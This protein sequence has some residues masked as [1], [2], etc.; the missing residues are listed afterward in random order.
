MAKKNQA[1]ELPP[2]ERI[3]RGWM[4]L[5]LLLGV[6]LTAAAFPTKTLWGWLDAD[7]TT[8]VQSILVS[9]GVALISAG[10]LFIFEPKLRKAVRKTTESAVQ[11]ATETIR[12]D[13]EDFRREIK[14]DV[15]AKIQ[16]FEDRMNSAISDEIS[17]ENSDL[18]H[19]AAEFSYANARRIMELAYE[20][21]AISS[22]QILVD[23]TDDPTSLRIGLSLQFD[24][25]SNGGWGLGAPMTED[26]D[27]YLNA[28]LPSDHSYYSEIWKPSEDFSGPVTHLLKQ[29]EHVGVWGRSKPVDWNG[30]HKRISEALNLAIKSRRQDPEVYP[31]NTPI[32]DVVGTKQMWFISGDS[33]ECPSLGWKINIEDFRA[34]AVA[35]DSDRFFEIPASADRTVIAHLQDRFQ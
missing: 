16:S 10:V 4:L 6:A 23:A 5:L 17:Q 8:V 18:D 13:I 3:H 35:A 33:I 29:L 26:M 20:S 31:V 7:S 15:D 19:L 32:F 30:V 25:P 1:P 11:N 21:N 12:E 22:A 34:L 2:R 24:Y 14:E 27:L 28:T 9:F